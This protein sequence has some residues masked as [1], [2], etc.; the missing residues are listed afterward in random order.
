MA[1]SEGKL[2]HFVQN[3][4]KNEEATRGTKLSVQSAFKMSFHLSFCYFDSSALISLA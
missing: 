4:K 3:W 1:F 2:K